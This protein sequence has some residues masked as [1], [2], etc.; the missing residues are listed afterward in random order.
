M[1]GG[2]INCFAISWRN[3]KP[4][5]RDWGMDTYV[6]AL[7][8]AVGA[9]KAISGAEKINVAGACAGAMTLAAL[10]GYYAAGPEPSPLNSATLLV[11][12]L[13]GEAE[14]SAM[15]LFATPETI[16][17]AKAASQAHGVLEGSEMGR[18]FAW[19][20]PNDLVWNYWVNNY[21]VGNSPPPFDILYW[22]ADTTRLPARFH[23]ELLD[24]FA[25]NKFKKPGAMTVLGRP[26]ELTQVAL[27]SYFVAGITDHITPWKGVYS[28]MRLFDGNKTFVLSAAGHIQSLINP[29]AAAAKREFFLNPNYG[30]SA[31]DWLKDAKANKGSWWGHWL[32]WLHEH[33]GAEVAHTALP[34]SAKYPP[35]ELDGSHNDRS[36]RQYAARGDHAGSAGVFAAARVQ[37]AGCEPRTARRLRGGNATVRDR[38]R[39]LRRAGGRRF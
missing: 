8:E 18:V 20:R 32:E 27:D 13:D 30:E 37:R 10:L 5:Q 7:I 17:S 9:V 6:S 31:G 21:L 25:Q 3:P 15:F 28:T 1:S 34:G 36:R 16:A 26:I 38:H 29:P 4:A 22:N 24:T 23:G 12:V 2:G 35:L 11:A 33:S 39:Y 19:L 14:S